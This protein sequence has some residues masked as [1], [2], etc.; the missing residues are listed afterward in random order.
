MQ[1]KRGPRNLFSAFVGCNHSTDARVASARRFCVLSAFS[2]MGAMALAAGNESVD[3][4]RC[5]PGGSAARRAVCPIPS[6]FRPLIWGSIAGIAKFQFQG[7]WDPNSGEYGTLLAI[8]PIK[9]GQ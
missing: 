3:W 2:R 9:M 1:C 5:K 8:P 7:K 4:V 6:H